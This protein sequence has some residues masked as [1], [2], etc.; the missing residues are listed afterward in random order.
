MVPVLGGEV[1][2][3]EQRLPI[4]GQA[5]DRLVVLGAVFVG[6]HVDRRLGPRA[7]RRAVYLAKVGLHIELNREGDLVQHVGGFVNPTALVPAA[8]EDLF[9]CLPEAERAV[10][11]REVGR[12]LEPTLLDVEQ[13]LTPARALSRTPVWKPTSS[14]L[15][16]GVAPISTSMHS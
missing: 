10:A 4:L 8:W 16:S 3:G 1:E 13:E 11:D 9:D 2:E 5:A 7:G 6:E 14:F 15:P 12:N